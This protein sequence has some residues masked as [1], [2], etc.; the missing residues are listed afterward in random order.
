MELQSFFDQ[1]NAGMVTHAEV[2]LL[3]HSYWVSKAESSPKEQSRWCVYLADTVLA[4]VDAAFTGE[5]NDPP[6]LSFF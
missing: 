3:L 5:Y 6:T 4:D 1:L 2:A